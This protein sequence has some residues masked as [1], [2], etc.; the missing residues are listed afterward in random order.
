MLKQLRRRF[1]NAD[2]QIEI[3][4]ANGEVVCATLFEAIEIHSPDFDPGIILIARE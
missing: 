4:R 1:T 2:F 3:R